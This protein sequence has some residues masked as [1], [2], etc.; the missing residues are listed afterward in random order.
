[1]AA[2]DDEIRKITKNLGFNIMILPKDQNLAEFHADDFAAETMP[3]DHVDRLAGSRDVLTIN[4]L[5]PALV[6]KLEWP[7]QK[8]QIIL[9]GVRGV[10]PFKHL[11][12]KKPLAQPVPP[13]KIDVGHVLAEQL[14]LAPGGSVT[15][16]GETFEVNRIY[17]A[18][19]N[20]DDITVWIDLTKAQQMLDL[21]GR[22]NMI[23]AL[24]CN[25]ASID[26][27]AEIEAEVS[28]V[29]GDEV[30]VIE[31][32][33]QAVARAKARTE[34]A[35]EGEATLARWRQRAAALIPGL[36]A[37]A[38]VWV[39]LL[40]LVDVRRRRQEIGILRALGMRSAQILRVFLAKP[41]LVGVFGAAIG[42]LAGFGAALAIEGRWTTGVTAGSLFVPG[43]LTVVLV[44]TPLVTVLAGWLPAV[45]A[46]GQ[47]PADVLREE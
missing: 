37:C 15:L 44:L 47:D 6:R 10:V 23:Q 33:T 4:H 22:I 13:G 21:N 40:S 1:V 18:R 45:Q 39:G 38:G 34:V 43:L 24:E 46:A 16:S 8:R 9:M 29:L 19:G 32:S 3:E 2:L 42:Y 27:L 7:E 26:R 17:P 12:E 28:K 20:K 11:N 30:Q 5:R 25:C 36:T 31:L 14:A 35:A 41:A